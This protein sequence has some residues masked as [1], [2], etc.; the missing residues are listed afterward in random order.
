MPGRC[1]NSGRL[2]R[3]RTGMAIAA[4]AL[5]ATPASA[6]APDLETLT[7]DAAAETMHR[8]ALCVG[9]R[10]EAAGRVLV[11][12]PGSRDEYTVMMRLIDPQPP[13]CEIGG[14][15]LRFSALYLRGGIAEAVWRADFANASRRAQKPALAVFAVPSADHA[16]LSDAQKGAV[17][18]VV[19]AECVARADR[20]SVSALL[21]TRYG[22]RAERSLYPRLQPAMDNCLPDGMAL[23]LTPL[24]LRGYLAEGAYRIAAT[25]RVDVP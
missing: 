14:D 8:F 17:G 23:K 15:M 2:R 9:M 19:F 12:V 1:P 18:L 7:N 22:S 11:T 20:A 5:V 3:L 6:Q 4:L 16:G 24:R 10:R 13:S 21:A 25:P